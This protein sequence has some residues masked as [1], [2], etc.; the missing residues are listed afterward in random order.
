MS[1]QA[2]AK[3]KSQK[4]LNDKAPKVAH[5]ASTEQ[6]NLGPK[7]MNTVD[8]ISFGLTQIQYPTC[9]QTV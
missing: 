9:N 1:T 2:S 8:F 5:P 3:Q 7:T 6:N 4:S